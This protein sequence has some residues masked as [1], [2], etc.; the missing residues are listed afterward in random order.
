MLCCDLCSPERVHRVDMT[1]LAQGVSIQQLSL[2]SLPW[3][4]AVIGTYMT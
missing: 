4:A 3:P 1:Q 2:C